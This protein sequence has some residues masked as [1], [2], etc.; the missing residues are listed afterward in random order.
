MLMGPLP[1][2]DHAQSR[3]MDTRDAHF[4]YHVSAIHGVSKR[5]Q[6]DEFNVGW[7]RDFATCFPVKNT[8]KG[9]PSKIYWIYR[10]T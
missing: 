6:R 10:S 7:C 8:P 9:K 4:T 3:T 2:Q 5:R 1:V